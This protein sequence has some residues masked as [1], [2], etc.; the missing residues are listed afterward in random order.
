M[1]KKE[2]LPTEIEF[3]AEYQVLGCDLSLKRPGFCLLS[4]KITDGKTKIT[5]IQ[6]SSI[7]NKTDKKKPHGQLLN[8]ILVH[9]E[10]LID[11][12]MFLVRE[13]EIMKMK[14]PSER[15]LSKV[16]GLMDW[17]AWKHGLEWN[18]IYPMTIKKL[19]T[20]S[21]RAEKQEV[22]DALE[23]FV[24]KQNYKCD[25]ESDAAAVAIAWLIQNK[26]IEV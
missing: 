24:G 6:L 17:A 14:V 20:G 3:P 5:D 9:F 1:A 18:S 22:A 7:N 12:N 19:I 13:T 11:R 8:E 10:S 21:G 4:L 16:V 26:Q 15:S 25:D 2:S 23:K